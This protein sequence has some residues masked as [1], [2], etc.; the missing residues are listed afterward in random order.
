MADL[1]MEGQIAA[2]LQD[3]LAAELEKIFDGFKLP[4]PTGKRS[5][6]NIFKQALPIPTIE[7]APE[8][9]TEEMLEEGLYDPVTN[10]DL[11]PYVIVRVENGTITDVN[12]DQS[13][14]VNLVIGVIDRD[15]NNQGHKDVLNIIQKIY[16]RFA[17]NSILAGNYENTFPIEWAL[18]D[19]Q[20]YPYFFGGMALTF[21]TLAICREDVNA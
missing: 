21:N 3:D 19:E 20:S 6:I 5:N 11:Y 17:K 10:E 2:F 15:K 13:V 8:G 18:Q 12:K 16:E 9:V 4:D 1:F 7:E 14:L